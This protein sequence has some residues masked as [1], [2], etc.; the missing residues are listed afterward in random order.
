M[1]YFTPEGSNGDT[2]LK[3][4]LFT[5]VALAL[6]TTAFPAVREWTACDSS[7]TNFYTRANAPS[8]DVVDV[9]VT[10]G[11]EVVTGDPD[12]RRL[13]IPVLSS[14]FCVFR[15]PGGSV[16]RI[17]RYASEDGRAD[18]ASPVED[19]VSDVSFGSAYLPKVFGFAGF[20]VYWNGVGLGATEVK[21]M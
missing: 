6:A 16:A 10:R 15:V 14:Q 12:G 1:L 13:E 18:V 7:R 19:L 17:V 11:A 21:E 20:L 2:A 8:R 9:C 5:L 4:P 3:K